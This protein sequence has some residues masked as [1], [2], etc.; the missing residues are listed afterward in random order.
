MLTVLLTRHGHTDRS[1]PEQYLGQRIQASLTERGRA[2]AAALAERLAG[3]QVD[4]II[5]S[6]LGRAVETGR[7][8]ASQVHAAV[9]TDDRL[10]ELDYG[11]WEGLQVDEI[12]ARFPGERDLYDLNPAMHEVGGGES[13]IEVAARVSNFIDDLLAWGVGGDAQDPAVDRTCV[14][15]GHSSLNRVLLALVLGVPLVDYRRR[16][17][18]DWASLTVLRWASRESG[19]LLMLANDESH[20]RGV[21]GATWD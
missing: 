20:I 3:V 14:V 21:E 13:G 10:T 12:D 5:T 1:T 6:P 11:V 17:K 2:D 9:E 18:Q 19:A 8:I 7:I 15:V 16:F 4:R